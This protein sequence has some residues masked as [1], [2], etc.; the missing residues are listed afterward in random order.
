MLSSDLDLL[1]HSHVECAQFIGP[2]R[3]NRDAPPLNCPECFHCRAASFLCYPI[4]GHA[5]PPFLWE[6]ASLFFSHL[7]LFSFLFPSS[8][9]L[10]FVKVHFYICLLFPGSPTSAPS[11]CRSV[12]RGSQSG[13]NANTEVCVSWW[14]PPSHSPLDQGKIFC[15]IC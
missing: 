3:T 15:T 9:T 5:I 4:T 11:H 6:T 13:E 14:K 1:S 7:F 12:E 8:V 2:I 10:S